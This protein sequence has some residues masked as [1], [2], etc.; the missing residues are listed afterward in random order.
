[1][2]RIIIQPVEQTEIVI[3]P[4]TESTEETYDEPTE[5]ALIRYVNSFPLLECYEKVRTRTET[6][7]DIN[8]YVLPLNIPEIWEFFYE[9]QSLFYASDSFSET[10]DSYNNW[11][12]PTEDLYKDFCGDPVSLERDAVVTFH[13]PPNPFAVTG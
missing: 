1:M 5:D 9:N 8:S 3:V 13:L 10:I 6:M 4:D 12:T 2:E 11:Y 7:Q